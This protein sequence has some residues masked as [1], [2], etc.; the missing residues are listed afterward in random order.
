MNSLR[1]CDIASILQTERLSPSHVKKKTKQRT[2]TQFSHREFEPSQSHALFFSI[3]PGHFPSLRQNTHTHTQS[4]PLQENTLN[5]ESN[6]SPQSLCI[7]LFFCPFVLWSVHLAFSEGHMGCL[8][9][10]LFQDFQRGPICLPLRVSSE[11]CQRG[12]QL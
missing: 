9:L 12:H 10:I 5:R 6:L 3:Q 7:C 8:V 2:K 4:K 11:M 1:H